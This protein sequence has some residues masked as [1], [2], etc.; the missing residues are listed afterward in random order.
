[1]I[2]ISK[3]FVTIPTNAEN[4]TQY[5][6]DLLNLLWKINL[7]LDYV[8]KSPTETAGLNNL[9]RYALNI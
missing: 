3:M 7:K 9:E 8:Y 6:I 4:L 2:F 5:N 1:M